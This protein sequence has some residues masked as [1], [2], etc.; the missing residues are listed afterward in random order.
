[1][2]KSKSN[3]ENLSNFNLQ[4][5]ERMNYLVKQEEMLDLKMEDNSDH[6][7]FNSLLAIGQVEP[8]SYLDDDQDNLSFFHKGKP[9]HQNS[10]DNDQNDIILS[11]LCT[12][13]NL[14]VTPLAELIAY[15]EQYYGLSQKAKLKLLRALK[16]QKLN[17]KRENA[18]K[19]I[20]ATERS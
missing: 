3:S 9:Q 15:S 12:L 7:L 14:R 19:R 2:K 16:R 4:G 18:K 6:Y 5:F 17:L 1:M 13:F 8:H 20:P 10:V 11:E